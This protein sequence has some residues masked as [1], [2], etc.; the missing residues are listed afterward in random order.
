MRIALALQNSDYWRRVCQL[1]MA[2]VFFLSFAS[3]FAAPVDIPRIS[4]VS[5]IDLDVDV[6]LY[7]VRIFPNGSASLCRAS[8]FI[9]ECPKETFDFQKLYTEMA[10]LPPGITP[11]LTYRYGVS[12]LEKGKQYQNPAGR[13]VRDVKIVR[14]IFEKFQAQNPRLTERLRQ[15]PPFNNP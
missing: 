8:E 5:E 13:Q 4:H 2:T 3:A 9:G 10:S 15:N 14:G 6:P 12:F 7:F 11:N 1:S